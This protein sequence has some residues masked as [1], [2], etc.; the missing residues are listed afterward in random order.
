LT[1]TPVGGITSYGVVLQA[2]ATTNR[3][4]HPDRGGV[5]QRAP[6]YGLVILVQPPCSGGRCED[7]A[8]CRLPPRPYAERFWT[9]AP[10]L[11]DTL[12]WPYRDFR[13]L[14][15]ASSYRRSCSRSAPAR[16]FDS[17]GTT[18]S[19]WVATC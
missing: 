11:G 9:S 15:A 1:L 18:R 17:R 7:S 3:R 13:R 4:E 14:I 8:V 2:R 6:G 16:C 19:G 12:G 10:G 5:P